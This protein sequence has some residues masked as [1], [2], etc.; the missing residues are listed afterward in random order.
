MFTKG[1]AEPFFAKVMGDFRPRLRD[2]KAATVGFVLWSRN[3]KALVLGSLFYATVSALKAHLSLFC[4]LP[5]CSG[6]VMICHKTNRINRI[7]AKLG[8]S[9]SNKSYICE[10]K[11]MKNQ[12]KTFSR[13]K[14]YQNVNF[15]MCDIKEKIQRKVQILSCFFF[16]KWQIFQ[17]WNKSRAFIV[18]VENWLWCHFSRFLSN[19]TTL[20]SGRWLAGTTVRL[21][22]SADAFCFR[23]PAPTRGTWILHPR[24][25]PQPKSPPEF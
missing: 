25:K 18:R 19:V 20:S 14:K 6:L 10:T 24:S 21:N 23:L 4:F 16:P 9:E 7:R 2:D 13:D 12:S 8:T 22:V 17:R 1:W 15:W 11:N 3:R 5:N